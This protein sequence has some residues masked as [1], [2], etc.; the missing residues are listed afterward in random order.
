MTTMATQGD[1]YGRT[2]VEIVHICCR[3]EIDRT[4]PATLEGR[5]SPS[6]WH[7]FCRDIQMHLDRLSWKGPVA[8]VTI[9]GTAALCLFLDLVWTVGD[10]WLLV[11]LLT[12][13][14]VL[15][16]LGCPS[17]R[18]LTDVCQKWS[19]RYETK[20]SFHLRGSFRYRDPAHIE[21]YDM[22]SRGRWTSPSQAPGFGKSGYAPP[23]LPVEINEIGQ[24]LQRLDALKD[25][26]TEDE[27]KA[28]RA[29]ILNLV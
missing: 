13:A 18:D 12:L 2:R 11:P 3:L 4:F 16:L 5:L 22:T 14:V 8:V 28:K 23:T 9:I 27:Y 26:I 29:E 10:V 17:S 1:M 25:M 19:Q 21:I 20:L 7:E 6:E 15:L 24:R